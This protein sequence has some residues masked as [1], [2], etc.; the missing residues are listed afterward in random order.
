MSISIIPKISPG[1]ENK[2]KE[3]FSAIQLSARKKTYSP[4]KIRPF[5]P[6]GG[7]FYENAAV[8]LFSYFCS[9]VFSLESKALVLGRVYFLP[10][11][12]EDLFGVYVYAKK[13]GTKF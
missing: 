11:S 12:S 7:G 3:G 2:R 4:G 8:R 5:F 1:C 9:V 6:A 10:I 13:E